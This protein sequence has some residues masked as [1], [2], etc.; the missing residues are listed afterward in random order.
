MCVRWEAPAGGS[1]R[2]QEPADEYRP[3]PELHSSPS[4]RAHSRCCFSHSWTPESPGHVPTLARS[5]ALAEVTCRSLKTPYA[6]A[7]KKRSPRCR[8]ARDNRNPGI[9]CYSHLT[10]YTQETLGPFVFFVLFFFFL[11]FVLTNT[12]PQPPHPNIL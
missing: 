1:G 7:R 2:S 12:S 8:Q 11:L 9:G 4:T 3:H 5:L 10:H 6:H